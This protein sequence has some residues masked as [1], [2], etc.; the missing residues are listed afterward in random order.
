MPDAAPVE[1]D[2]AGTTLV[3]VSHVNPVTNVFETV[4]VNPDPKVLADLATLGWK[5]GA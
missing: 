5:P 3:P 2:E 1:T 4:Y